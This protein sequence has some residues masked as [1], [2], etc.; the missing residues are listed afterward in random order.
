VL[1]NYVCH[2]LRIPLRGKLFQFFS[3]VFLRLSVV[4]RSFSEVPGLSGAYFHVVAWIGVYRAFIGVFLLALHG[5]V[6]GIGRRTTS[7]SI[8]RC[9]WVF[10]GWGLDVEGLGG[11]DLHDIPTS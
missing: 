7:D 5:W 9:F 10:F 6:L 3:S 2:E 4:F 1:H 8:F 11:C